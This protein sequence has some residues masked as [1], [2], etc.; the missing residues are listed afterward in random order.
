MVNKYGYIIM[1]E[2]EAVV[3]LSVLVTDIFVLVFYL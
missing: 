3:K 2:T 1:P